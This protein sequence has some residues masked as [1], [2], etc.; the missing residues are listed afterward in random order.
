[1]A[2]D[3]IREAMEVVRKHCELPANQR[4]SADNE[5][6]WTLARWLVANAG[7]LVRVKGLDRGEMWSLLRDVLSQGGDIQIDHATKGYESYSARLDAAARER[8]DQLC[9]RL[10]A[11]LEPLLREGGK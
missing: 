9:S 1:M 2:T 7:E 5:A 11:A 6:A 10:A 8:A 4:L 3:T